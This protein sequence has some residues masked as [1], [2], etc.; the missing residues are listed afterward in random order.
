MSKGKNF[1]VAGAG[2]FL[3]EHLENFVFLTVLW[4][5]LVNREYKLKFDIGH[6]K[7]ILNS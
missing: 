7:N 2:N 1:L 4:Y 6:L 3:P 5:Q